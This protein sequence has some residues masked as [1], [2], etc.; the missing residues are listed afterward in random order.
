MSDKKTVKVRRVKE[1]DLVTLMDNIVNEKVAAAKAE[2]IAEQK[3]KE[4]KALTED[5]EKLVEA[6]VAA[7]LESTK[8]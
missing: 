1:G 4:T 6:K 5:I 2:W 7:I 8:K 3:A